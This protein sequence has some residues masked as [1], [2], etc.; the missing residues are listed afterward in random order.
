MKTV[1][2]E[3]PVQEQSKAM[4]PRTPQSPLIASLPTPNFSFPNLAQQLMPSTIILPQVS[5]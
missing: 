3:K 5:N 4:V 2:N 1:N